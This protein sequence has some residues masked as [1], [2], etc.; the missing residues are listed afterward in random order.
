[1]R[2]QISRDPAHISDEELLLLLDAELPS[3]RLAQVREHLA[4]CDS[5]RQR[6]Q[7][8]ADVSTDLQEVYW[9]NLDARLPNAASARAA[10]REK[11][12]HASHSKQWL[13]AFGASFQRAQAFIVLAALIFGLA[14]LYAHVW[15]MESGSAI[16][17]VE[18]APLPKPALTPGAVRDVPS[19]C[20]VN[21]REDAVAVPTSEAKQVFREYG[22]DYTRADDYELDY[23]ITP[24]LGGATDIRNLWPEPHSNTEWNSYIKDQLEDRLHEMVCS[25]QIDLQTAQRDIATNWIAAYK[26]YF[27]TDRPL[28]RFPDSEPARST[29]RNG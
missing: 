26:R 29:S 15:L 11:L 9:Q 16:L 20:L 14:E 5:C 23:L 24:A 7:A 13:P 17:Q 6:M 3:R 19:I 25:G 8:L 28:P 22:M 12:A 27:H 2:L 10:L 4:L 18:A 21:P 1:M